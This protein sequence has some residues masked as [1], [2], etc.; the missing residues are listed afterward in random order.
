MFGFLIRSN[1]NFL[2]APFHS[3]TSTHHRMIAM[4]LIP[5]AVSLG[6]F[7]GPIVSLLTDYGPTPTDV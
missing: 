6:A 5:L 3:V 7:S 2:R 4:S 1:P